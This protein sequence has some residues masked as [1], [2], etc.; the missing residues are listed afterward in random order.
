MCS[1][2]CAQT[3][4]WDVLLSRK[5]ISKGRK[6]SLGVTTRVWRWYAN[7]FNARRLSAT[8]TTNFSTSAETHML[9]R[10]HLNTS[11]HQAAT[12]QQ[13]NTFNPT[14][15]H[16]I[17]S[18]AINVSVSAYREYINNKIECHNSVKKPTTWST[19]PSA[20]TGSKAQHRG[21]GQGQVQQLG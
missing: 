3:N 4:S 12:R 6:A 7:Q 8:D 15:Q 20:P 10:H 9:L 13:I 1:S 17:D 16:H 11:T 21:C 5:T 19:R 2:C 18:C 14:T